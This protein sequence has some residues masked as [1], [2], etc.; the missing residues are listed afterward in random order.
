M[1]RLVDLLYF[2]TTLPGAVTAATAFL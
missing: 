2:T 1:S